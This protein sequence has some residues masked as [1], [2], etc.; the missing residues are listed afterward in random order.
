MVG[1][2]P[3]PVRV[4]NMSRRGALLDGTSLPVAGTSVRLVRGA[5][6]A[7]AV[8]AWQQRDQAGIRFSGEIDVEQWVRRIGHGA[9]QRIDEAI[10][11]LRAH[12]RRPLPAE[13]ENSLSLAQMSAELDEISE[14]LA[15]SP[16]MTVELA[17]QLLRLSVLARNLQLLSGRT[18][19]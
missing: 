4:R 7:D 14:R 18:K 15:D 17:E 8:V 2:E 12:R 5:L 6:T 9:Q 10:A 16:E 3:L 1:A 19:P 13:L 11:R